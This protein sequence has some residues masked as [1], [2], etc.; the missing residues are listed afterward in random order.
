MADVAQ[1]ED[2]RKLVDLARQRELERAKEANAKQS[3]SK[4]P[5]KPQP[6]RYIELKHGDKVLR[7]W[8]LPSADN[9]K[10]SSL[11]D[12]RAAHARHLAYDDPAGIGTYF[13]A[14]ASSNVSGTLK[15]APA[16]MLLAPP[17]RAARDAAYAAAIAAG[18]SREIAAAAAAVA[19]K[20]IILR[21]PL[22][23]APVSYTHLTLPTI[24]SV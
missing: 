23:V 20:A 11:R 13:S 19:V 21:K 24:C 4:K 17:V 5:K 6:P 18:H 14:E 9:K 8:E 10:P 12:A 7:R 16:D 22:N 3:D 1:P 15:C 2:P